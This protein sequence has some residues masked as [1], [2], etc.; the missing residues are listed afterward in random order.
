MK[1]VLVIVLLISSTACFNGSSSR[2]GLEGTKLPSFN[3]LLMDS[4]T[5]FDTGRLPDEQPVV[6]F[7]VSPDCPTCRAQTEAIIANMES[8]KDIQFC[9]LTYAP[10]SAFKRFYKEYHL[11]KYSNITAGVDYNNFF[12]DYFKAEVVPYTAIYNSKKVLKEVLIGAA[13]C[14]KIRNIAID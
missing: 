13:D 10:F 7:F 4:I 8:L 3:L 6:L 2:T 5:Q 9:V 11:E 12:I 14:S 1:R